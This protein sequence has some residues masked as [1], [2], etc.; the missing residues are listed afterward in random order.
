MKGNIARICIVSLLSLFVL[1]GTSWGQSAKL[2]K[3]QKQ[4]SKKAD[5]LWGE[6][7]KLKQQGV[8]VQT[9]M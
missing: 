3:Q 6:I 5:Q 1:G 8:V 2:E 9:S 4:N 7:K